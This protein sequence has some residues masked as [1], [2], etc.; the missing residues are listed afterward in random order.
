MARLLTAGAETL[1]A[2]GDNKT[3][4]GGITTTGTVTVDTGT[5]HS[6]SKSFKCDTGAG[7]TASYVTMTFTGAFARTY[8][9]RQWINTTTVPPS[10]QRNVMQMRDA[11]TN[12]Q[13]SL[14]INSSG[15]I[16]ASQGAQVS[17][18]VTD[19]VWHRVEMS[20]QINSG[21]GADDLYEWRVDGVTIGS[22]TATL[23]A[24]VP[25]DV[26]LGWIST[27]AN[28]ISYIDD[29]ALNDS[30]GGSQNSFPGDG[31]QVLLL[32][33]ADSAI[34]TG[35]TLGSGG[36]SNLFDAV[37]NIPPA[38]VADTGA[39]AQIR[40]AQNTANLNYDATMTTYL[41]AG[42]QQYHSVEVVQPWIITAAPVTTSAKQGTV[43]V[44]SNPT[45]AN[46]ALA[47][48]GTAGAFWSG[49][50]GGTYPTGWKISPGTLTYD[51]TVTVGTAP[52]MR[53]TQV[54]ASTRIAMVCG[55]FMY[56]EYSDLQLPA[57]SLV[58]ARSPT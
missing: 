53:V 16:V 31:R 50:A 26:L 27:A 25:A 5:V 52:V 54:T 56:V 47:A 18:V 3:M 34:G 7:S 45:I 8:F 44:V 10:I 21:A 41:A 2:I 46:V 30:T 29:V 38:G 36:T 51:P 6:G 19:G 20:V 37:N 1:N 42:I 17:K 48:G 13:F 12:S 22:G 49:V 43:G 40:S 23:S 24:N 57:P 33:T 14:L 35:W 15:Q 4:E 28:L 32:P 39:T 11:S 9:V 58:T 55:M